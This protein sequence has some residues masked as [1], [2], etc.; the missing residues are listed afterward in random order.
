[1]VPGMRTAIDQK[2]GRTLRRLAHTLKGSAD[3][4]GAKAT[5]EA[6]QKVEFMA[7]DGIWEGIEE[8]WVGLQ[9]ELAQLLP[10]LQARLSS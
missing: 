8:A 2:D 9:A 1:M 7:R 4:F 6:A 3:L 10:A 5:V